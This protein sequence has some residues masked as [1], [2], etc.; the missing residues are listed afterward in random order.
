MGL[1]LI[2]LNFPWEGGSLAGGYPWGGLLGRGISLEGV[3]LGGV[4]LKGGLSRGVFFEGGLLGRGKGVSLAKGVSLVGG[5]L[6][7]GVFLVG[8]LPGRGVSLAGEVSLAD[9][10][11]NRMTD[12]CEN[13][14][15]PQTSFAGGNE[16]VKKSVHYKMS[17][18]RALPPPCFSKT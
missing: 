1:D 3:S 4:L 10:P 13:I 18:S 5:P 2:P 17:E 9:L 12:A 11:V 7:R 16:A 15:L 14:T 6:G 8:G